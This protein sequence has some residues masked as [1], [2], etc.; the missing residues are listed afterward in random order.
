MVKEKDTTS[1]WLKKITVARIKTH[2]VM[3]DTF[4]QV[5]NRILDKIEK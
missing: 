5:L 4:D 3:G 1:V 2:G